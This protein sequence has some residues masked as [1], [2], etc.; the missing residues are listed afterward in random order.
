MVLWH[1]IT[2]NRRRTLKLVAV[3]FS[4]SPLI[5]IDLSIHLV[6]KSVLSLKK[7]LK[8]QKK[9]KKKKKKKTKKKKKKKKKKQRKNQKS[10][11][12]SSL[13]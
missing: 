9:K 13:N 8:F 4:S 10:I 1:H 2:V 7:A 6:G 12:E 5:F 3:R 11:E